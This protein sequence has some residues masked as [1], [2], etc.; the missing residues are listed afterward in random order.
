VGVTL[1]EEMKRYFN[2]ATQENVGGLQRM[3]ALLGHN[4]CWDVINE[5][6]IAE[7][8]RLGH[9]IWL[10]EVQLE[11]DGMNLQIKIKPL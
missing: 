9:H 8:N 1:R 6:V 7:M 3:Q 4:M 11:E 2:G 10:S 5:D